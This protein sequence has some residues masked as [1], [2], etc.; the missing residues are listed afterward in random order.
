MYT[1]VGLEVATNLL[2]W[3][4]GSLVELLVLMIFMWI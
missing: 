3:V 2:K 1:M 4:C